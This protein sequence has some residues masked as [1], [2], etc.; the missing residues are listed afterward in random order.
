MKKVSYDWLL[1]T[2]DIFITFL[3][4]GFKILYGKKVIEANKRD[5]TFLTETIFDKPQ[6][7][8]VLGSGFGNFTEEIEIEKEVAY[9]DIPHFPVSTVKGHQG[10][11]IFGK[12]RGKRVVAMA[13]RFHFYEGYSA[14]ELFFP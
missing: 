3:V 11:L 4:A 1:C 13:G 8:I 14:Q 2:N 9:K 5:S 10:K 7:G 12:L 6:V